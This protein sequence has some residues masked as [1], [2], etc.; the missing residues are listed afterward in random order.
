MALA[1]PSSGFF[2][3]F[4]RFEARYVLILSVQVEE[5]ISCKDH[6]KLSDYYSLSSKNHGT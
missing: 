5:E 4:A 1:T 3:F 6:R 2:E